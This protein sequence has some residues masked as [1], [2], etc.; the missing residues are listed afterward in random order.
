MTARKPKR[1]SA[2]AKEPTVSTVRSFLRR[3]FAKIRCIYF[4]QHLQHGS[5][6]LPPALPCLG[7]VLLEL[8]RRPSGRVS[9]SRS[10]CCTRG[11][12][13]AKAQVLHQHSCGPVLG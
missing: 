11:R 13:G 4:M 7:E 2:T 12:G 9:P 1:N 5:P 6:K 10:S 3:R 8:C